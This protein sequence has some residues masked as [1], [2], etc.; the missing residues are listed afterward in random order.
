VQA[1][2]QNITVP[3]SRELS[4]K[5][6]ENSIAHEEAEVIVLF[7]SSSHVMEEKYAAIEEA[8]KDEL[9]LADL[10]ETMNDF[11]PVDGEVKL[12]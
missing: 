2:K 4:I 8:M 6:Q 11:A 10:Y 7:K 9:F 1:I 12:P 5:L 3:P